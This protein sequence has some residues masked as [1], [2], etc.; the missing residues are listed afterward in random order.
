[1]A[2][3]FYPLT[4]KKLSRETDNSVVITFDVPDSVKELFQYTQGQNLTLKAVVNGEEVRRSYS[5]CSAPFE[6]ELSIAIKKAD[7]GKFSVHANAYMQKGDIIEVFP[8]TGKFFTKL[9]AVNQKHYAAFAA[10]SGITPIISIIKATLATESLSS[11]T[12]VYG[13]RSR[14]SIM[15]FE[16]LEGLK[17]RYINRFNIIH[18]LSREKTEAVN[19][20][21]IDIHKL[22][23]LQKFMPYTKFD[24]TFICGPE[25]MV[26]CVK[27]F[28]EQQGIDKRKIHFELFNTPGQKTLKVTGQITGETNNTSCS[29]IIIKLDG[30]SV[31]FDLAFDS[32]SILD[33]ALKQ[34]ADLPFACKGGVCSTCK[35]KLTS[36]KV[37]MDTNYALEP[38]ELDEGYIL[39]C[40]SHPVSP[41]VVI[42]YDTR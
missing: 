29:Q 6:N 31:I 17:N 42:D 24:E 14:S 37:T 33:A 27:D 39:T 32:I 36:G 25:S 9:D 35:A 13:N 12:L 38:E 18:I 15:F 5:I 8:P 34:G 21:K 10:G 7:A 30:R 19:F 26:F 23:E 1:M 41:E 2:A 16:E 4:V 22:T 20:G 11:F 40:Q 3:H 28:L